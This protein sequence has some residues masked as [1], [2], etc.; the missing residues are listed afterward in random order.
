MKHIVIDP[1]Q[2]RVGRGFFLRELIIPNIGAFILI[3]II[4]ILDLGLAGDVV[5]G[6]LAALLLWSGNFAAPMARMHDVGVNGLWHLPLV[7]VVFY[8]TTIGIDTGP[9]EAAVKLAD[10]S[11]GIFNDDG[12][13]P[14]AS[15]RGAQL[16]GVLALAEVAALCFLPGEKGPNA[17]GPDP[18]PTPAEKAEQKALKKEAKAQKK[19][20]KKAQRS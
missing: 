3:I 10:W 8:L 5:I 14:S 20:A 19:R 11:G 17:Y 13:G 4:R 6:G 16:G 12:V 2:R 18:R 9:H 15:G 1:R 7:L